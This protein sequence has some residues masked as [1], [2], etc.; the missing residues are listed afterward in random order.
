MKYTLGLFLSLVIA[1]VFTGCQSPGIV[2]LS[3]DTYMITKEDHR[4]LF[5]AGS[6]AK[7]KTE[8]IREANAFA[9]S[10]GKIAIPLAVK[11]HP[12]GVMGDW[13][14][15]E[16]QFS[17]VVDVFVSAQLPDLPVEIQQLLG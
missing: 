17:D 12:M 6:R 7:L 11:E 16:L 3:P 13:A 10:K 9:E 4:G 5:G 2:Q 1:T 8:T 14:S 15:V